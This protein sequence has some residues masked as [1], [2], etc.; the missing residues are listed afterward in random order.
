MVLHTLT[1][2]QD[3]RNEFELALVYSIAHDAIQPAGLGGMEME[4]LREWEG[5]FYSKY[6]IVG[7]VVE[8]AIPS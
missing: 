5:R 8:K 6:D 3:W 1:W 7:S 2:H 4:N